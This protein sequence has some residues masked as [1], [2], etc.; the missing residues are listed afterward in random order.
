[1]LFCSTTLA[2]GGGKAGARSNALGGASTTLSDAWSGTN[3]AATLSLVTRPTVGVSYANHYFLPEVGVSSLGVVLPA[4]GGVFGASLHSIAFE[5]F[6]QTIVGL[7]YGRL[8]SR[9][10]A[11]GALVNGMHIRIGNG[12]GSKWTIDAAVGALFMP[13]EDL[14]VGIHLSNP[15]RARWSRKSDQRIPTQL[16]IGASQVLHDNTRFFIQVD[17]ELDHPINACL[18]VEYQVHRALTLR[19]GASSLN[20][21]FSL[22]FKT[23]LRRLVMDICSRWDQRL[24]FGGEVSFSYEFGSRKRL[25]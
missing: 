18:G 17:K 4:G 7:S 16:S 12:Y 21:C 20:R 3:N 2:G 13:N 1:M 23:A 22:G 8:L 10:F 11:L 14:H 24:G 25:E 9:N 6:G 19:T 15:T 5:G